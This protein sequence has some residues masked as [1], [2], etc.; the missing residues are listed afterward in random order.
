MPPR[1]DPPPDPKPQPPEMLPLDLTKR[2]DVYFSPHSQSPVVYRDVLFK[3]ERCIF[4]PK[5]Q[6]DRF[7]HYIELELPD[8][9]PVFVLR[10]SII[11]FCEAGGTLGYESPKSPPTA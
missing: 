4:T 2:Y 8:G 7:S 5:D 11:A 9:R 1:F 3:R 10:M 6:F